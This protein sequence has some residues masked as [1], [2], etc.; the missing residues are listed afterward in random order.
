MLLLFTLAL[1]QSTPPAPGP[2][3]EPP[4]EP[5]V[6]YAPVTEHLF[7]LHGVGA[8]VQ[9]P[10]GVVTLERRQAQ[11]NPLIVVRPDWAAEIAASVAETQ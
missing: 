10:S 6:V 4:P 11:F 1:A 9:R 8:S 2:A 3:P 5:R 7:G